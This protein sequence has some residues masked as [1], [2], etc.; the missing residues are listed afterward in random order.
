[1]KKLVVSLLLLLAAASLSA[2]QVTDMVAPDGSY[3][4]LRDSQSRFIMGFGIRPAA[5]PNFGFQ[6]GM[7]FYE[8]AES[9]WYWYTGTGWSSPVLDYS[10]GVEIMAE[11]ICIS[12]TCQYEPW[13]QVSDGAGAACGSPNTALLGTNDFSLMRCGTG[14]TDA[15][16]ALA[17]GATNM[18]VVGAGAIKFDTKLYL[19]DLST[20]GETYTLTTGLSDTVNS[21]AGVDEIAFRY[22][23]GTY[24]GNWEC[25]SRSNS[26]ETTVNSGMAVTEDAWWKLRI[27]VNAAGTLVNYYVNNTQVCQITTNIPTGIARAVGIVPVNMV[28]SVGITE[29]NV[30]LD[31]TY[32]RLDFTTP[33]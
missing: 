10:K 30:Y 14:T 16:R 6:V 7:P 27:E 25:L 2:G 31:Y 11:Y 26:T 33:R 32:F 24:A 20:A 19:L 18:L 17:T 23:H 3:T 13:F 4:I 1:M 12:A 5:N 21:S 15:G 29:R 8:I 28:K 9:Q 22:T